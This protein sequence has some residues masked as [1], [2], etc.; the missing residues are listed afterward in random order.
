MTKSASLAL[1]PSINL[2]DRLLSFL[3]YSA[4]LAAK[5]G[6]AAYFGM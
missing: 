2:L 4:E 3:D 6:D 5:N 1:Q